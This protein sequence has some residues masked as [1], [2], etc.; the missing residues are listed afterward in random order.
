MTNRRGTTGS[1]PC[2][3]SVRVAGLEGSKDERNATHATCRTSAYW[4]LEDFKSHIIK[5]LFNIIVER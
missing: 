5:G 4:L 3:V 1:R 2:G